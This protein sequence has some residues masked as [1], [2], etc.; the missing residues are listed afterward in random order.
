MA[1]EFL[2]LQQ[3]GCA[4]N[5]LLAGFEEAH[6]QKQRMRMNPGT[7][8]GAVSGQAPAVPVSQRGP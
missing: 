7:A 4:L 3:P 5:V 6:L 1:M 2:H 8:L